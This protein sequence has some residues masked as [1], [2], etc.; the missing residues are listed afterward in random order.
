MTT[1]TARLT[2]AG[3]VRAAAQARTATSP[4]LRASRLNLMRVGYLMM[5]VGLALT[6]WPVILGDPASL[7]LYEGVVAALLTAM[8]LFALVG[9]RYPIQLLPLLVFESAWKLIWLGAV[10]LPHL[11]A[12]DVD[13]DM[14]RMLF[15]ISF[16][17]VILAVTPW[18][19]VWQ[20]YVAAPGERW[21]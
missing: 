4:S 5:A 10:A 8:S 15:S 3:S 19:H 20:R 18:D 1:P 6:K 13:A 12:G 14:G 2:P 11:I 21:R 17:V 7:P 16:V 9:L